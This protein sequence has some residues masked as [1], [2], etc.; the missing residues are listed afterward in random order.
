MCRSPF[1]Y[2][3][4]AR[5]LLV[6]LLFA[7]PA[8]FAAATLAGYCAHEKTPATF[9]LGHHA[10]E[11]SA[12]DGGSPGQ[13]DDPEPAQSS[14]TDHADCSGCHANVVQLGALP[15]D[16]LAPADRGLLLTIPLVFSSRIEQDIDRPKWMR[17]G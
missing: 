6:I 16:A 4:M 9:H 1:K 8:Q 7:L 15:Q 5:W 13:S 10:H 17:T 12:A 3:F 14:A 11:H 2:S